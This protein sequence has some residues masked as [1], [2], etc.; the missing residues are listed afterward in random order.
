MKIAFASLDNIHVNEHFGWCK[1]FYIYEIVHDCYHFVK[2]VDSSYEL[3][4]EVEKLSYKINCLE[5]STI[6]YVQQ[7]GPKASLMVKASNIF[8]M[9]ASKENEKIENVLN[10]LIKMKE[11]PPLWMKR[12]LVNESP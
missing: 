12:L 5:D 2:E 10:S 9:Q 7:I 1:K 8:P 6:L 4:D 11:N 3:K